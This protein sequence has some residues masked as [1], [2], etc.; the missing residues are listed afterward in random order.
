MVSRYLLMT[1]KETFST[2]T[3]ISTVVS[4]VGFVLT[5][6]LWYLLPSMGL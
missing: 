3:V 6:G 4:I 5:L 1:E 2:W